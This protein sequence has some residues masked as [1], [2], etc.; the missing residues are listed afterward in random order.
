[1]DWPIARALAAG[2]AA[3]QTDVLQ[4]LY[5]RMKDEPVLFDLPQVFRELGVSEQGGAIVYDDAAPLAALRKRF[6]RGGP[7]QQ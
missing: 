1:V 5:A 2:D 4:E 3:T 7:S 6:V